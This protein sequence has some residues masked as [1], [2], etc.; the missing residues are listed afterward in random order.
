MK[1]KISQNW[2]KKNAHNIQNMRILVNI[3]SGIFIVDHACKTMHIACKTMYIACK[4]GAL[5]RMDDYFSLGHGN[6]IKQK[7]IRKVELSRVLWYAKL[8]L[9]LWD[10]PLFIFWTHLPLEVIYV[11]NISTLWIDRDIQIFIF[12]GPLPLEAIYVWSFR[13]FWM[14]T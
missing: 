2:I 7:Q 10:I 6:S 11:W 9:K 14:F 4:S 12:W 5:L 8:H 3:P 1:K 13:N